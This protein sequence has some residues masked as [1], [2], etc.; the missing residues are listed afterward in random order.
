[1]RSTAV[2]KVNGK[3]T[4][5]GLWL[6]GMNR[7]FMDGTIQDRCPRCGNLQITIPDIHVSALIKK[8][9]NVWQQIGEGLSIISPAVLGLG[10][11]ELLTAFEVLKK[12]VVQLETSHRSWNPYFY[13]IK[14]NKVGA[15]INPGE[16][17]VL[18]GPGGEMLESKTVDHAEIIDV[19]FPGET[20]QSLSDKGW[21]RAGLYS[22][23]S[24]HG[25]VLLIYGPD[26]AEFKKL[27]SMIPDSEDVAEIIGQGFHV[28]AI[29]DL[30]W[31]QELSKWIPG[32]GTPSMQTDP[33]EENQLAVTT[34]AINIQK[35]VNALE[36]A[37]QRLK[38]SGDTGISEDH[39]AYIGLEGEA[40]RTALNMG[41]I[42]QSR[43]GWY[44]LHADVLDSTVKALNPNAA[45]GFYNELM[46]QP[47]V[48]HPLGDSNASLRTQAYL[49]RD[50]FLPG[51]ATGDNGEQEIRISIGELIRFIRTINPVIVNYSIT[52]GD[53][54]PL[55]GLG[56]LVQALKEIMKQERISR[57]DIDDSYDKTM[58]DHD[59]S[60][61]PGGFTRDSL[62]E[63]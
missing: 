48:P 8:L 23:L 35:L 56:R 17:R 46:A 33:V 44:T 54:S 60:G 52:S 34:G 32:L 2:S 1:M 13:A 10:A 61:K 55:M 19:N 3:C 28:N 50:A 41:Y 29:T 59:Y 43:P 51:G 58:T 16:L 47:T 9:S 31:K 5:C 42:S 37:K 30:P 27:V 45:P 12:T 22:G 38:L 63:H 21:V 20:V 7:L 24:R 4:N 57:S 15:R 36:L 26:G 18:F 25:K 49:G 11:F 39:M 53:T 62:E 6:T 40:L 14:I